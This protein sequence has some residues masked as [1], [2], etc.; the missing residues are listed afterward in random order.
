MTTLD[1]VG[2]YLT[3]RSAI[4]EKPKALY[5]AHTVLLRYVCRTI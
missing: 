1:Y 3:L 2:I 5:P 4:L